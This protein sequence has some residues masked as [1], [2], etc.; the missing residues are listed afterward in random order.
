MVE[1]TPPNRNSHAGEPVRVR[2]GEFEL[3]E[4]NAR[5][6]RAGQPMALAPTPFAL[7]CALAR[8]PTALLTK[9]ALLDQVWGHQFV[10]DSVLKTAISDLRMVLGDDPRRPRY[11][12]TVAR[13]GYRFIAAPHV[14]PGSAPA[15]ETASPQASSFVG[16]ADALAR[17]R[18]AWDSARGGRRSVVWVAGEPGIG[19]TTLID[20]FVASL[21][22]VACARGHCVEHYGQGEAYLPV[23]E[24]LGELSRSDSALLPLL[25]A[26]A[27]AWLLQLPWLSTADEREALRRELV[28]VSPERML[29]E[30]GELLDRYTER[31]PLLLV[32]ED[33]HWS[34]RAT[35]QLIDYIARRRGRGRLMWLASFRLAEVVV[36]DHPMNALRRELRLHGLCEEIVLD[37]FSET[38]V[39]DYLARRWPSMA[40]DEAFVRALHDRTEGVPLFVDSVMTNAATH[41]QTGGAIHRLPDLQAAVPQNL[42][43]LIDHYIAGLTEEHRKL[44]TAAAICGVEFRVTTLALALEEDAGAVGQTCAE[45]ARM[46]LWLNAMPA[47]PTDASE[48]PYSFRHALFRQALYERTAAASR[49]ELHRRVGAALERERA[50]GVPAVPSELAMHFERGGDAM[51]ALRYY[52]EA[53]QTSLLQLAPIECLNTTER[54]LRLVERAPQDAE[55]NA[56]ELQLAT[57][58]GMSAFHVLGAGAEAKRSLQ[59]AYELLA[60]LPEHPMRGLLLHNFG[61]VLCLR[62]EYDEA[63]AL[64]DRALGLPAAAGDPVLQLAA[65]TAQ[66]EVH[67]LQGRPRSACTLIERALPALENVDA[68]PEQSFA[69]VTLLGLL[70]LELLQL[71]FVEQSRARIEQAYAHAV[72]LGLPMA[73]L[74]AIWFDALCEVRLGDAERVGALADE[75]QALVEDHALAHGRTAG[76]WFRGWAD[77]RQGNPH[78]GYRRIQEACEENLRLGMIAG[79]S[80]TLGYA[81]EALVLAGEW[82]AAQRQLE[83]AFEIVERYG[84]RVYLPQLLLTEAAIARGRGQRSAAA[85]SLRRAL[86]EARTQ[87]A[88]WLELLVLTELCQSGG[89]SAK[90]R[91]ALATL[92][93][94]LPEA[95]NTA[96][97]KK[98]GA[99]PDGTSH[100]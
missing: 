70:G 2:F 16:R 42:T 86:A 46:Q 26:V 92:L 4:A 67:L 59:R 50:A 33:L 36:L 57:L 29:R 78:Q 81:A 87:E 41:E 76:R 25:R 49:A 24:A 72:R 56:V 85:V 71:G 96:V 9:H 69:Q 5:L 7:L 66:G 47:E 68:T 89:A 82:D 54:A 40:G 88:R 83:E 17:L 65:C 1:N 22:G 77:S 15:A 64:A 21:H 63:L 99:L 23:L 48:S 62:A 95:R 20:H 97:L 11:I 6:L 18:R 32:T 61:F 80:E 39:A 44:L 37:S 98:R 35:I 30:M 100:A 8:Q 28:G 74:V 14:V 73:R 3:D 94:Q 55:R 27:P 75:M 58:H 53:A 13:R 93:Q 38:E 91:Q 84:E 10:S 60:D 52:A 31:Q 19:K 90:E 51:K 43:A 34:D 45:L 12:E 79:V